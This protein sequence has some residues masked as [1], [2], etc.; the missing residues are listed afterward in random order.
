MDALAPTTPAAA[1]TRERSLGR[2]ALEVLV[3]SLAVS[4]SA[5]LVALALWATTE[6]R[7]NLAFVYLRWGMV[8]VLFSTPL[9]HQLLV[10]VRPGAPGLPLVLRT[11]ATALVLTV[12][13]IGF[14]I[15]SAQLG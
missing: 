14:D 3:F 13:S 11:P 12:E 4:A 5:A 7:F 1:P 6:V 10:R 15:L 8:A 9:L 2:A